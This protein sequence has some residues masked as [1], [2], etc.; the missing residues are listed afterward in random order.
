MTNCVIRIN[1]RTLE[2]AIIPAEEAKNIKE[3]QE[4]LK[5]RNKSAPK[6][7]NN[8]QPLQDDIELDEEILAQQIALST[9]DDR[10]NEQKEEKKSPDAPNEQGKLPEVSA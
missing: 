2:T 8:H 9:T 7:P 3:K 10:Q 1:D 5:K 6:D 4:K